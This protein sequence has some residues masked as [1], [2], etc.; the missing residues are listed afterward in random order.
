MM[1]S[2]G[3]NTCKLKELDAEF[4]ANCKKSAAKVNIGA[5]AAKSRRGGHAKVYHSS[6]GARPGERGV[7]SA[8]TGRLTERPAGKGNGAGPLRRPKGRHPLEHRHQIPQRSVAL[9][10]NLAHEPGADQKP[11]QHLPGRCPRARPERI[12]AA[13][14]YQRCRRCRRGRRGR[15]PGRPGGGG[16]TSAAHLCPAP[17][18]GGDTHP[19]AQGERAPPYATLYQ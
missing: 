19:F 8:C 15:P 16:E 13:I 9:A 11:A 7:V 17:V 1:S 14:A 4:N 18:G 10:G 2:N 3:I 5:T 6:P 12:A